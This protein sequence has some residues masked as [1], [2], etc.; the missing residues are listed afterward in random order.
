MRDFPLNNVSPFA[1]MPDGQAHG[2]IH[3]APVRTGFVFHVLGQATG[4]IDQTRQQQ[5]QKMLD[6]IAPDLG[7]EL[8]VLSPG[9]WFWVGGNDVSQGRFGEIAGQLPGEFALADQTHGR[10]R[11]RLTGARVCDVL[12]KGVMLDLDEGIFGIR[13]SAMTQIGHIGAMVTRLDRD[14]FEITVL[15]SFAD[16][17]WHELHHMAAEFN[18]PH[19]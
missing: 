4:T 18:G 2:A 14:S 7:G 19:S 10:V 17:L 16:S 5:L 9:Q 11:L 3:I 8:R 6:A 15:R 12:A 1:A 13:Q